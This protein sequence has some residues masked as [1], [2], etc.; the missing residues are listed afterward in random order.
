MEKDIIK[1][2]KIVCEGIRGEYEK[3][4]SHRNFEKDVKT[5]RKLLKEVK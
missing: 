2:F 1:F 4:W 5:L 3:G